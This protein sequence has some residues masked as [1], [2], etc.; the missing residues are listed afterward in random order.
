MAAVTNAETGEV[1]APGASGRRTADGKG[2]G[3]KT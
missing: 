3:T 1:L 2:G